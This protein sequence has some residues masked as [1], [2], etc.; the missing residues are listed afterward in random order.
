M[1][2]FLLD[3]HII[4]AQG[5]DALENAM[6][7]KPSSLEGKRLRWAKRAWVIHNLIGHPL[8][9]IFAFFG[10]TKKAMWIHDITVPKPLGVKNKDQILAK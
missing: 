9:Q 5:I 10:F 7:L 3:G 1:D 6:L 8:M 4:K 2:I